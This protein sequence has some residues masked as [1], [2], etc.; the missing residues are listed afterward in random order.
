MP[1]EVR[2]FEDI[3]VNNL[4]ANWPRNLTKLRRII[5]D[6]FRAGFHRGVGA[7][8]APIKNCEHER[9]DEDGYCRKCGS[10][11]RGGFCLAQDAPTLDNRK[12][13]PWKDFKK[14]LEARDAPQPRCAFCNMPIEFPRQVCPN[15]S[16]TGW[17]C[18]SKSDAPQPQSDE[19]RNALESLLPGRAVNAAQTDWGKGYIEG[20]IGPD[21]LRTFLRHRYSCSLLLTSGLN[22]VSHLPWFARAYHRRLGSWNLESGCRNWQKLTPEEK[23]GWPLSGLGPAKAEAWKNTPGFD[24]DLPPARII[25]SD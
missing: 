8:D 22:P 12:A 11:T 14:E 17:C 3:L 5:K 13:M 19:R 7:Q 6:A 21:E 16:N 18:E 23:A 20:W 9:V 4:S 1:K 10:D 2:D 24:G 15:I 25:D